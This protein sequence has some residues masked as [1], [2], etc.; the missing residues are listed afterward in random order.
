[1][2]ARTLSV[3]EARAFYDRLGARLDTQAF[4]EDRALE[5]LVRHAGLASARSVFELGCGTGRLARRLLSEVLPGTARYVGVDISPTMVAL[6]RERLRPWADR[7][8][9]RQS[10]GGARRHAAD[11][12]YDRFVS[13]FVLD[14]MSD[15]DIAAAIADAGH[16]L[17][18]GGLL[19]L[20][21]LTH[22]R[23]GLSALASRL[24]SLVH[25]LHPALVGGC[26]P[27]DLRAYLPSTGWTI[28]HHEVVTRWGISSEV[29]I[30][31]R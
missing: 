29:L 22:G 18:P 28:R 20:V 9:V 2:P 8:Q 23:G 1:M 31:G 17:T 26:R 7:A 21:G 13:T 12:P 27:L 11:G 14:L 3:D 30:T 25:R 16:A 5:V 19:C 24:W 10:E 4:Y 15:T 6:A